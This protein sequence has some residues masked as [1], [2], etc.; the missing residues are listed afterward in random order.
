MIARHA[1]R[2]TPKRK[3]TLVGVN[4]IKTLLVESSG[5]LTLHHIQHHLEQS[6]LRLC[7]QTISQAVKHL[8]GFSRKRVSRRFGG[9]R[10]PSAWAALTPLQRIL[11]RAGWAAGQSTEYNFLNRDTIAKLVCFFYATVRNNGQESRTAH[12]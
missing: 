4:K 11:L 1:R 12:M 9:K 10:V 6:G 5:V 8:C 7:R 3:L 2:V